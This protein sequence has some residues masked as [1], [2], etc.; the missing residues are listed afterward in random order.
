MV[1]NT[2]PLNQLQV[3]ILVLLVYYILYYS[4]PLLYCI[5]TGISVINLYSRCPSQ[6]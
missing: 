1:T 2:A 5:L 6:K 3:S 4:S